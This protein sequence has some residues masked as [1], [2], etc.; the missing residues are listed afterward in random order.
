MKQGPDLKRIEDNMRS[1]LL[2]A[3]QFLGTDLR[4]LADIIFQDRLLLEPL[5]LTARAIAERMR[6]FSEQAEEGQGPKVVD[7]KFEV[8]REEHKGSI[9]CPF[10]DNVQASKSITRL[11]NLETGMSVIWSDL[12]IHLIEEHGF[13][14]GHGAPFRIEPVEIAQVLEVQKEE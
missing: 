7:G 4:T 11:K 1:G 14:E 9:L 12:N 8:E 2:A 5:G 10:A 6:Y 13:F 3:H